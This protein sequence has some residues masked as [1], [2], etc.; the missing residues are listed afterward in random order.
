MELLRFFKVIPRLSN[1][2]KDILCISEA[3]GSAL[4]VDNELFLSVG[5][6]PEHY[7]MYGEESTFCKKMQWSGKC[8]VWTD[9]KE[10][11][12]LHYHDKSK[13]IDPWRLYLMGRNRTLEYYENR[14][15]KYIWFIPYEIAYL[16]QFIKAILPIETTESGIITTISQSSHSS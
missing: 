4:L 10:G 11:Y 7:F 16:K 5:G 2:N 6:F 1:D 14:K 9:S 13:K 3:Q 15:G 12:V 8:I